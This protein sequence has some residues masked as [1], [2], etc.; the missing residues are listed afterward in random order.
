MGEFAA[1]SAVATVVGIQFVKADEIPLGLLDK[2]S[3]PLEG[4]GILVLGFGDF[5]TAVEI[6]PG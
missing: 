2:K 5:V 1:A 4:R 3:I 6:L